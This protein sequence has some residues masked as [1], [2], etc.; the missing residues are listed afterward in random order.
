ME[1]VFA[2]KLGFLADKESEFLILDKVEVRGSDDNTIQL[3]FFDE[4]YRSQK[5]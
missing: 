3:R 4:N 5:M 2:K 1:K